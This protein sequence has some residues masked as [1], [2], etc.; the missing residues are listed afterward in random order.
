MWSVMLFWFIFLSS[1]SCRKYLTT[2]NLKWFKNCSLSLHCTLNPYLGSSHVWLI[3]FLLETDGRTRNNTKKSWIKFLAQLSYRAWKYITYRQDSLSASE[4]F[5]QQKKSWTFLIKKNWSYVREKN[6]R[7]K[8]IHVLE[9]I[10]T[11]TIFSDILMKVINF[12]II[13]LYLT[14]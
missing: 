7:G 12:K 6:P 4:E 1:L 3:F 8:Q 2:C 9:H 10:F 5:Q 13:C 11:S 14:L